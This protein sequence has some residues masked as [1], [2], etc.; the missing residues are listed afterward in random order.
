MGCGK[1]IRYTGQQLDSLFPS[2]LML[3]GPIVERPG[4]DVL[5]DQILAPIELS[6]VIDSDNVRVIQGR[7]HSC[8]PLESPHICGIGQLAGKKLDSDWPVE[9]GIERA[10]HLAHAALSQGP[11]DLVRP[12]LEAGGYWRDGRF[13]ET[14]D[15]FPGRTVQIAISAWLRQQRFDF[16]PQFRIR[17]RQK[18][19]TLALLTL[20]DRVVQFLDLFEA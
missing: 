20:Q 4:I 11:F 16:P 1:T 6:H 19:C 7:R 2:P 8:F 12:D 18:C 9:L 3:F 5:R 15:A 10:K 14:F 17:P 13:E